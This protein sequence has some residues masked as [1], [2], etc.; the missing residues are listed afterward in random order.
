MSDDTREEQKRALLKALLPHVPFDGWSAK[1]LGN[2]AEAAGLGR[3]SARRLFP[4][5]AIE[6]VDFFIAE[7][8]RRMLAKLAAEDIAALPI[9]QRIATAVRTRLQA[10]TR[11]KEVVRRALALQMLPGHT[12][13]ALMGLYRTVDAMWWACG[14]TATDFNHYTKRMLLAGVYASTLIHWLNDTSEDDEDTWD[15]LDRRIEDVMKIQKARG[16]LERVTGRLPNPIGI[17][18]TLRYGP[19]REA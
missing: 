15:F 4:G 10:L 17:L 19:R 3:D 2:A 11:D 18:A 8:D 5:G 13:R 9:R 16:R 7:A 1:A 6:A 14:D 12:P